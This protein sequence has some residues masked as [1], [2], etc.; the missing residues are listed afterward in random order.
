LGGESGRVALS[1]DLHCHS[2]HSDGELSPSALI[3]RAQANQVTM[4]SITDHDT[5]S[6][7]DCVDWPTSLRLVPG[8][9]FSTTWKNA[10]VHIV[11][12]NINPAEKSLRGACKLQREGRLNRAKKISSALFKNGLVAH[13]DTALRDVLEIAGSSQVGRPH[14]ARYLVSIGVCPDDRSAFKSYLSEGKI[15][16]VKDYWPDMEKAIKWIHDA[17]GDSVLAHPAKYQMSRTRL[18]AMIGDFKSLG[19]RAIEIYSGQQGADVTKTMV[20]LGEGQDLQS[21]CGSDFHGPGRPWSELGKVPE[22]PA[23]CS[24]VWKSWS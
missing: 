23:R 6:A 14:F 2:D 12:L 5:V 3:K 20:R 18:S 17:G 13:P 21:S 24:P 8:V 11:G 22:L 4:M 1:I 7:Y 15:G 9:E 19:G 16:D 10:N